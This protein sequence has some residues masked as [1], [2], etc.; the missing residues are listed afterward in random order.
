[1][2]EIPVPH[3]P[4]GR[5]RCFELRVQFLHPARLLKVGNPL[6]DHLD[7]RKCPLDDN[8]PSPASVA[9]VAWL[10]GSREQTYNLTGVILAS[11]PFGVMR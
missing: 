10:S 11:K 4:A 5:P 9:T 2:Q 3:A 8:S 7:R 1:V 6:V